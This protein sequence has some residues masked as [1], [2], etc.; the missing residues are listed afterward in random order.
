VDA[1]WTIFSRAVVAY[2]EVRRSLLEDYAGVPD[3]MGSLKSYFRFYNFD[4]PHQI[5]QQSDPR[6]H[7]LRNCGRNTAGAQNDA[8]SRRLLL[9]SFE[10]IRKSI[11]T[12]E[13]SNPRADA[14]AHLRMSFQPALPLTGC[15]PALPASASPA[16]L[17]YPFTAG[18]L[19]DL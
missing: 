13:A 2:R 11:R 7:L 5:A 6:S 12:I 4:R 18:Q 10:G 17:E 9:M 15:S 8:A 14:P 19:R 1:R 16:A 3:A